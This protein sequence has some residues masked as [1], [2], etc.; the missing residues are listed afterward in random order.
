[1]RAGG[2]PIATCEQLKSR[3]VLA[4]RLPPRRGEESRIMKCQH[5]KA[6][7]YSQKTLLQEIVLL[8]FLV[9]EE[10]QKVFSV[11]WWETGRTEQSG[12]GSLS[13]LGLSEPLKSPSPSPIYQFDADS[14]P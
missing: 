3:T 8:I 11:L 7:K 12:S 4:S 5:E 6:M 14:E 9:A 1:M 10:E 13:S 2:N